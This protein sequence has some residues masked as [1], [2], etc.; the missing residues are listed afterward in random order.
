VAGR[1]GSIVTELSLPPDSR[2][3]EDIYEYCSMCG[4]C[5]KNCPVNAISLE[6]GKNHQLCSEFQNITAEKCKPRYGCGKCQVGVPCE[7]GIP[8]Q[9]KAK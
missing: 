6:N 2:E 8:K 1:F 9:I 7:S 4:K 5:V 3:Y